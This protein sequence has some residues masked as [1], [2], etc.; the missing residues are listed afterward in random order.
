MPHGFGGIFS[1]F[2]LV[3]FAY[4]GFENIVNIAEEI[5][6]PKKVLPRAIILAIAIT[7]IIYIL[8]AVSAVRV[9]GWQDLST[10]LAPL[11]DV[12]KKAL[13]D[14]WGFGIL[15]I[16]LFA[17]TNTILIMLVSGSR[18]L[19]GIAQDRALPAVFSIIHKKR[20]TP[21]AAVIII[22]VLSACFVFAG[23]IGTVANISVF[24]I[25]MVFVLVNLSLIW[26]R[27]KSPDTERQFRSPINI[28]KFPIL[29]GLGIVT[30][31]LGLVQLD[32]FVIAMGFAVL[33]SG[34]VFY[35]IYNKIISK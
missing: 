30:P 8:V 20:K 29:A 23:D 18:I 19:Y 5:K 1:A 35:Y 12:I 10:S 16:A 31:I 26:L 9:L 32:A 14:Q 22:G 25:I 3:F 2:T 6:N 33:G 17:T 34:A 28:R 21:W 11:A 24:A 15:V 7:A 13:G 27:Y 4:V